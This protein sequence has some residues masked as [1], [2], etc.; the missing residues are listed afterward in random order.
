MRPGQIFLSFKERSPDF[1]Q[2]D[3]RQGLSDFVSFPPDLTGKG[4]VWSE[5]NPKSKFPEMA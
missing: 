2:N 3:L 5:F 1:R 4:E